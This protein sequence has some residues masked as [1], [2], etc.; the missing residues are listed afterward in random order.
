MTSKNQPANMTQAQTADPLFLKAEHLAKDFS[1]FPEHSKQT[2]SEEI[3]GLLGDDTIQ[4]N[5][6]DLAG[7][8]VD[9]Y[10]TKVIQ[11][12]QDKNRPGAKRMIAD[13]KGKLITEIHSGPFY[14]AEIELNF[15]SRTRRIGFIAQERTTA[16][17][18][19]MPEHHLACCKAIRH[20]A[21]L[22]M[23]IIYLIDTPGADAGEIANSQ[24]QAHSI[25]KAIAESANV[26]VPTVGI[27]IGAGYSGGAIPLA[28]ANILLSLRDGI[29]NTI[30]PQ[31]LQSIAR[32]YNLSWQEC[33]KS[34]GVSPEELYTSGCIDG[35]VDFSPSDKDERQHNLRR[36]IISSVE[37]VENA[38]VQFVR[39]SEDLREHYDRSLARFLDPSKNLAALEVNAELAVANNPTMHLNLFGSAYRYLRYL[40]LRSR[41]HS[42]SQEQY[43]RLSKVS[44][45]EGDLLA[46][47]QQEQDKVFQSWLSS[48]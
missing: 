39:E 6:K 34:V 17:G 43:G 33:A 20:F 36:A 2:L 1:L 7:L 5:L 47:I 32:K 38:A 44:V 29:F 3:K 27:V 35:I 24:N 26:D 16:N 37:A 23:P 9:G 8:D 13:L 21:E 28:A 31:G 46:R 12:T 4:A 30:Q 40:T 10:V 22:S 11:P 14:S 15:G 48:P 25:S 45:P 18:A 19:W 41:I 42:I